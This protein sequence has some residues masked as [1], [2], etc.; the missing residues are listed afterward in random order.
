MDDRPIVVAFDDSPVSHAAVQ[1]AAWLAA[2]AGRSLLIALAGDIAN[3]TEVAA[4]AVD[5]SGSLL[6]GELAELRSQQAAERID[7]IVCDEQPA[8]MIERLSRDAALVVLGTNGAGRFCDMVFGSVSYHVATGAHCPVVL[9]PPASIEHNPRPSQ[10]IVVGASNSGNGRA[11]VHFAMEYAAAV[12]GSVT[13]VRAWTV[14][15]SADD[16]YAAGKKL[17][18]MDLLDNLTAE[19]RHLRPEVE[20]HG[21]LVA[22]SSEHAL[23]A[24]AALADLLVVGQHSSSPKHFEGCTSVAARLTG[25]TPCPVAVVGEGEMTVMHTS[26]MIGA[27]APELTAR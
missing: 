25:R 7:T 10:R 5:E 26:F 13:I 15:C 8:R 21:R 1:W 20:V 18:E 27:A 14:S 9:I 12:A 11:A 23:R 3:P 17:A 19:A 24:A 6:A 4:G 16:E 22:G 2:R